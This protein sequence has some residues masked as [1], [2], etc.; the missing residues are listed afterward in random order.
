P[1]AVSDKRCAV[2]GLHDEEVSV[3]VADSPDRIVVR[4][5]A[6]ETAVRSVSS[7]QSERVRG[8]GAPTRV[9]V[10]IVKV[11]A[12]PWLM[13]TFEGATD[14]EKSRVA[15]VFWTVTCRSPELPRLPAASHAAASSVW[16]PSPL[17]VVSQFQES[18]EA[19][20]APSR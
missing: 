11:K 14:T 9:A 13:V 8:C 20:R 15:E 12:A 1:C 6:T 4:E 7:Q 5:N 10:V 2:G 19:T 3:T 17:A 18:P 16:A